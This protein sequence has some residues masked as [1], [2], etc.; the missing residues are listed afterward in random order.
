LRADASVELSRLRYK[1]KP[2][3]RN[4]VAKE[5]DLDLY[6]SSDLIK[7]LKNIRKQNLKM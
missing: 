4:F 6:A 1:E 3:P 7:N 5:I 2:T